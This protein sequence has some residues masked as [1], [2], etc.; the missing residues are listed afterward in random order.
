MCVRSGHS[1]FGI[2]YSCIEIYVICILEW[3]IFLFHSFFFGF[4]R[5]YQVALNSLA[6]AW[7]NL[8]I[9]HDIAAVYWR[10]LCRTF[11]TLAQNTQMRRDTRHF[12]RR[13]SNVFE[14]AWRNATFNESKVLSLVKLISR[15]ASHFMCENNNFQSFFQSHY[16]FVRRT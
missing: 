15:L 11:Y 5:N 3:I 12:Q 8:C 9:G 7:T 10:L 6:F 13:K 1:G 4:K 2:N 16:N 14:I